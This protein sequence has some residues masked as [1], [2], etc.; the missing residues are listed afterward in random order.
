MIAATDKSLPAEIAALKPMVRQA[1]VLLGRRSHYIAK[2]DEAE[3]RQFIER[4]TGPAATKLLPEIG[5]VQN[6]AKRVQAHRKA[7]DDFRYGAYANLSFNARK[8]AELGRKLREPIGARLILSR[9][10]KATKTIT[11]ELRLAG[12]EIGSGALVNY[13]GTLAHPSREMIQTAR[14]ALDRALAAYDATSWTEP[15]TDARK[16]FP[17]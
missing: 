5:T 15:P 4:V 13:I 12:E 3:C 6:L 17:T 16:N 14:D 10:L 1:V 9:E 7:R 8:R 11:D 2:L